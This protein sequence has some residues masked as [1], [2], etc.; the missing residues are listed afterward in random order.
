MEGG[1][2]VVEASCGG[3]AAIVEADGVGALF[4]ELGGEDCVKVLVSG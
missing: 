4:Y 1:V 3:D 2:E